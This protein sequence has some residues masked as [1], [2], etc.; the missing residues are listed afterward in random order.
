MQ[1]FS[2]ASL[3]MR[4]PAMPGALRSQAAKELRRHCS[5]MINFPHSLPLPDLSK[6]G[7]TEEQEAEGGEKAG[8]ESHSWRLTATALNFPTDAMAASGMH[9]H[10][11]S[12]VAQ[13]PSFCL[14]TPRSVKPPSL[15]PPA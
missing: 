12:P 9:A 7:R 4:G 14:L 2:P 10:P 3:Q 5:L 11:A 1:W 6:Q 15:C 13:D 8:E